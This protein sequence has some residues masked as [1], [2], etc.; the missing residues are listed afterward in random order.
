MAV[1][2]IAEAG[3]NHNGNPDLAL[4]MVDRA[5]EAGCDAV[6]FQTFRAE[7][8]VTKRAR[9]AGY[10]IR[11]TG[12]DDGQ[13]AMLKALELSEE[14]HRRL[15]QACR[16]RGIE[17]LS[18]P[19]D[20][21]SADL[22]RALGVARFKVPSGE[23]TNRP[24]LSHIASF[25]LPLIVSTGMATLPEIREALSWIHVDGRRPVPVTLLHC[26]SDY[27]A[28]FDSVNLTA[29]ATLTA[30]FGLPVGYSDHTEGL[31]ISFAAVAL[32]ACVLEKHFTLD[33]GLPGPDHRMSLEPGEL[34]AL[35]TGI[36]HIEAAM[37][38]G[39]KRPSARETAT[40]ELVRKSVVAETLIPAG[41][42]IERSMLSVK[43]PAG[44]IPPAQIDQ[45]VG[46]RTLRALQ[47]DDLV[48]WDDVEPDR[49]AP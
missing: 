32:G 43:R 48:L 21:P 44:G 9:K 42:T 29:M 25:G 49:T 16:S 37:G 24:L 4:E 5:A 33:R 22:L 15:F 19:F 27:P 26:T 18:T 36:R 14:L 35:V 6:K 39:I 38:D 13:F 30:E 10:Q 31:E 17:F 45:L 41:T 40:A 23:L 11:N 34:K 47:P 8:L 2:I 46:R 12:T 20:E 7:S 1:Y 3:V 28:P